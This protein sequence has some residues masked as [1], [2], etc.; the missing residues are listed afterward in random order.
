MSTAAQPGV[1]DTPVPVQI[2]QLATILHNIL[3]TDEDFNAPV[4]EKL[5]VDPAMEAAPQVRT[6]TS[7]E[8]SH[9]SSHLAITAT[10]LAR[11]ASRVA[12]GAGGGISD[13]DATL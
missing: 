10:E 3:L 6:W 9:L 13:D 5:R 12:H 1:H 4:L 2:Q 7:E 8:L 11:A